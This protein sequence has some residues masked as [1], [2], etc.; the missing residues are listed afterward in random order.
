MTCR[1]LLLERDSKESTGGV[2]SWNDVKHTGHLPLPHRGANSDMYVREALPRASPICSPGFEQNG[3][4]E[5]HGKAR[6]TAVS[7]P[8]DTRPHGAWHKPGRP[9]SD[10]GRSLGLPTPR[11]AHALKGYFFLRVSP[12]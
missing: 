11:V 9:H 10:E 8:K 1:T 12:E 5:K 7:W 4:A 2:C 6:A 3:S